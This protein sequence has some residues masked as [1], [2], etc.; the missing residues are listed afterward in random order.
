MITTACDLSPVRIETMSDIL[1]QKQEEDQDQD[2]EKDSYS[3][4][5][6]ENMDTLYNLLVSTNLSLD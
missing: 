3:Y 4:K 1:T 2:Q 5:E 6:V